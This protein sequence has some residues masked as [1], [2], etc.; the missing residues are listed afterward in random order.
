MYIGGESSYDK[1]SQNVYNLELK[2][3]Q[4]QIK[5]LSFEIL[6]MK[7]RIQDLELNQKQNEKSPVKQQKKLD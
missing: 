5:L 2:Q 6:H 1:A 7:N 4:I 3:Q